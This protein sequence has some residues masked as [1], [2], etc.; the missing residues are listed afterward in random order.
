[1]AGTETGPAGSA[2]TVSGPLAAST[3]DLT[4]ERK[5]EVKRGE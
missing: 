2:D 1:V 5:A 3:F 4:N